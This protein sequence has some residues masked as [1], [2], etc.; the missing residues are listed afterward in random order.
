L[1]L[2]ARCPELRVGDVWEGVHGPAAVTIVA[3]ESLDG[4][5][6][7]WPMVRVRFPSDVL[8]TWGAPAFMSANLVSRGDGV[9]WVPPKSE[10]A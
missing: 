6:W 10:A 8:E 5:D 9:T 4:E 7:P 1:R 3:F 2:A